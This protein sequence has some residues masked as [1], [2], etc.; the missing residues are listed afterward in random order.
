MAGEA[1]VGQALVS[2]ALV[3]VD[4]ARHTHCKLTPS[5]PQVV[6]DADQVV[7]RHGLFEMLSQF[8]HRRPLWITSAI[9]CRP[10]G[11]VC[12]G[13]ACPKCPAKGEPAAG[14]LPCDGACTPLQICQKARPGDVESCLKDGWPVVYGGT[15]G[16]GD[17]RQ[18]LG[19]LLSPWKR[20]LLLPAPAAAA[21]ANVA[22]ADWIQV[23]LAPGHTGR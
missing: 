18:R 2:K 4:Q 21:E 9:C 22:C 11:A 14:A 5:P 17:C 10:Q 8:D 3:A 20:L 15:G 12:H 13:L 6:M 16:Q 19:P 23:K 7:F 1:L